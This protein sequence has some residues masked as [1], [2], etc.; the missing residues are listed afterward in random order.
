MIDDHVIMGHEDG[1]SSGKFTRK[2]MKRDFVIKFM[3]TFVNVLFSVRA[4]LVAKV[5]SS[6]GTQRN[7]ERVDWRSLGVWNKGIRFPP[8]RKGTRRVHLSQMVASRKGRS[9]TTSN[10]S[11]GIG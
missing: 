8:N 1:P 2:F 9:Y 11:S 10:R 6:S 3:N 5:L 4:F 7:W